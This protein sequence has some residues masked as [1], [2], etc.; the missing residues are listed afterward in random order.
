M[1]QDRLTAKFQSAKPAKH[2]AA[3]VEKTT[4]AKTIKAPVASDAYTRGR[5][6][7]ASFWL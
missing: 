2:R 5:K 6:L 1:I 7:A 4:K 3:K